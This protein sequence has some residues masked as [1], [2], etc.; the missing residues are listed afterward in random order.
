MTLVDDECQV[1]VDTFDVDQVFASVIEHLRAGS[2]NL[3][4]PTVHRFQ[5]RLDAVETDLLADRRRA[6]ASVREV[7]EAAGRGSTRSASEA[8]K[9]SKRAEVL[10]Q[11][12][13]LAGEL[14]GGRLTGEHLDAL[15][16][17]SE[18]SDG[19]AARDETLIDRIKGSNPDQAKGIA[20][21]W[22]DEHQAT[23]LE[24][25]HARQRRLRDVSSPFS[26][27]RGTKALFVEG[28]RVSLDE[29]DQAIDRMADHL[30][31]SDG[32]RDLPARQHPR[33]RKQRRF[34]AL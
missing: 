19:D 30:Y 31:R 27:E 18:Q 33:T 29:I 6:G 3:S 21:Q 8:R 25:E 14:D 5:Q 11:N 32:G 12:P 23:D 17:A 13:D 1:P 20:R 24:S 34:V 7:E 26:T 4:I 28:D 9:R 16:T 22:V 10:T 2:P 15:A